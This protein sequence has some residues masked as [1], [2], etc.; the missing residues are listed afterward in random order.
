MASSLLQDDFAFGRWRALFRAMF[1]LF[2]D[3][4]KI[5]VVERP[6]SGKMLTLAMLDEAL[7]RGVLFCVNA[8]MRANSAALCLIML[9]Q[10][11]WTKMQRTSLLKKRTCFWTNREIAIVIGILGL[12]LIHCFESVVSVYS[13]I[14][15]SIVVKLTLSNATIISISIKL[16]TD[17][18]DMLWRAFKLFRWRFELAGRRLRQFRSNRHLTSLNL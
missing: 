2:F 6:G 8:Q 15:E 17:D 9:L 13:I 12:C 3:V 11:W 18:D 1:S 10:T 14:D 16:V 4:W 7:G 5:L